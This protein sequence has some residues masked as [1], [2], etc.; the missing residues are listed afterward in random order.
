MYNI[1][2]IKCTTLLFITKYLPMYIVYTY[3]HTESVRTKYVFR[4]NTTLKV[5]SVK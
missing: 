4:N 1:S 2:H 3:I 5:I